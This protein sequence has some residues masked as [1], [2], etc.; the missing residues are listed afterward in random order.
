MNTPLHAS[1]KR[2]SAWLTRLEQMNVETGANQIDGKGDDPFAAFLG[3]ST[4][5]K[6]VLQELAVDC[7]ER[8]LLKAQACGQEIPEQCWEI[9]LVKRLWLSGEA[10][11]AAL[12]EAQIS[13]QMAA[14]KIERKRY[15]KEEMMQQEIEQ[16]IVE[17]AQLLTQ[18]SRRWQLQAIQK[19]TEAIAWCHTEGQAPTSP[20]VWLAVGV[21]EEGFFQSW[22]KGWNEERMW[23]RSQ[24]RER[25]LQ[26]Q[27]QE[28]LPLLPEAPLLKAV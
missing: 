19:A 25:L 13:A 21:A 10:T 9:L 6:Q 5:P 24:L 18:T 8:A 17:A 14:W 22:I 12:L 20:L 4:L 28:T 15:K 27:H 26:H 23:Q 3:E 16:H 11:D 7:V 1:S 2:L